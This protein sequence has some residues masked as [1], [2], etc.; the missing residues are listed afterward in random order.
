[1]QR[2]ENPK[3]DDCVGRGELCFGYYSRKGALK[4]DGCMVRKMSYEE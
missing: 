2:M 3:V 4:I 1:M